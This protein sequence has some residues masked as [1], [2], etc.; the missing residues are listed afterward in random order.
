VLLTRLSCRPGRANRPCRSWVF[1][2]CVGV[3]RRRSLA[4]LTARTRLCES[5]RRCR[6]RVCRLTVSFFLL[7]ENHGTSDCESHRVG[8]RPGACGDNCFFA[9]QAVVD[10]FG[11]VALESQLCIPRRT[12]C[13]IVDRHG[14]PPQIEQLRQS[15]WCRTP[16]PYSP[17]RCANKSAAVHPPPKNQSTTSTGTTKARAGAAIAVS[18]R[19]G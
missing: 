4:F 14:A 8:T 13:P 18:R 19:G 12:N 11:V 3:R 6:G 15:T 16:P 10:S 9:S 7:S 2:A 5:W 17:P 1:Q